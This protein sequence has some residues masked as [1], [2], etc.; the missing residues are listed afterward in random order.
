MSETFEI[1][2]EKR[3]YADKMLL[4]ALQEAQSVVR[5]YDT[6]AQIVGVGY[7]LALNL[8]LRFGDLLPTRA[9]LG[10]LFFIAV[11]GVVILPIVQFGQVLY[12]SRMRAE[13]ALR[14][15]TPTSGPGSSP[16]Y[17]PDPDRFVDI[18]DC[19]DKAVRADWTSVLAA[20]LLKVSYLRT[21]KRA[22]FRRGLM[23]TGFS[24]LVLGAEQLL[25]SL[26]PG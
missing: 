15:K 3:E 11:W 17:Y 13:K 2:R 23:M 9:P 20:E 26:S 22:R 18:G 25:R 6:K 5:S 10:P 19:V 12:P 14:T 4:S 24:F 8:V 21:L 16:L 1:T 7:I